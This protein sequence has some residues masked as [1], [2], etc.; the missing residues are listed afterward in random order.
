MIF[1]SFFLVKFSWC[2]LCF[3]NK[4]VIKWINVRKTFHFYDCLL[5]IYYSSERSAFESSFIYVETQKTSHTF[6]CFW[7][8]FL[9]LSRI[10]PQGNKRNFREK[11][12]RFKTFS[13]KNKNSSQDA[14]RSKSKMTQN[15][16]ETNNANLKFGNISNWYCSKH[17]GEF[18]KQHEKLLR[19]VCE[20]R[21]IKRAEGRQI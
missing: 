9:E 14:R 21:H 18:R 15:F 3:V 17:F 1:F 20:L 2:E 19:V 10:N 8:L 13:D 7:K 4:K 6:Y 11:L 16:S 5:L 12:P